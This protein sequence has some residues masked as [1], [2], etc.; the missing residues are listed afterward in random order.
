MGDIQR[1]DRQGGA[2][3][4]SWT[5]V[6]CNYTLSKS[7]DDASDTGTTN[8]EYNLPQDPFAMSL[9]KAPSSFDHRQRFTAINVYDLP[10]ARNASGLVRRVIGRWR[11]AGIFTAQ[12]GAPFTVN[13]SSAAG[14]NVSPIGLVSG[15]NLERP[16]LVGNPNAGPQTAAEWFNTAAFALP[17]QNTF[18]TAGR[19]VVTGPGLTALDLSLQKE[20]T[21]YER[22]KLQ[23]RFDVYNSLNHPNFNLPGRIFDAANFGVISSAGDPREMQVALKVLF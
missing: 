3:V 4:Q 2:P 15:N 7:M 17:A 6:R 23:L 22:L 8:A 18:G 13:L 19:N 21:L 20:E 12:S 16:N 10:F 9:E 1:H 14:Q 5:V 11:V